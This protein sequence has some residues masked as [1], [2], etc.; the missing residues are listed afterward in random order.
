MS[1]AHSR[2]FQLAETVG[3][4]PNQRGLPHSAVGH[5]LPASRNRS[6]RLSVDHCEEDGLFQ[7]DFEGATSRFAVEVLFTVG[8]RA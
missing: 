8:T 2:A 3:Q 4:Q 7:H 5:S 6:V 1:T